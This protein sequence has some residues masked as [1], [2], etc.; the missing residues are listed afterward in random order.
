MYTP[1]CCSVVRPNE[2]VV[3]FGEFSAGVIVDASEVIAGRLAGDHALQLFDVDGRIRASSTNRDR[4]P[5]LTLHNG[6]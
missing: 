2:P 3:E 4:L 1:A 6:Y 5:G